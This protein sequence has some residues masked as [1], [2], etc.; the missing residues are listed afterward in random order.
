MAIE[1]EG[2]AQGLEVVNL[3]H[4]VDSSVAFHAANPAVHMH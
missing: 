2:H 1:A 4:L 3:I